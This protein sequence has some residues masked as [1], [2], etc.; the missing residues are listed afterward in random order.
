[1]L[2]E[3]QQPPAKSRRF[4][5]SGSK[6]SIIGMK[7]NPKGQGKSRPPSGSSKFRLIRN[8]QCLPAAVWLRH[9]LHFFR[10]VQYS[11]FT[12]G[13]PMRF[14]IKL[15]LF[16]VFGSA[17]FAASFS[18][19]AHD[20]E[21]REYIKSCRHF[22]NVYNEERRKP[23]DEHLSELNYQTK[24]FVALQRKL[25]SEKRRIPIMTCVGSSE[26]IMF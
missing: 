17:T 16:A 6:P 23:S 22:G 24:S 10:A 21:D 13:S 11:L 15:A 12:K 19:N 7:G 14:V 25:L 20:A 5:S 1:L 18:K 8:L 3:P 4:S 9:W 2:G 26:Q